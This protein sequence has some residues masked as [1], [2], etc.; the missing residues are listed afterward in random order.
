MNIV[1]THVHVWD[2]GHEHLPW[3]DGEGPVLKRNWSPRDYMRE[4]RHDHGYKVEQAIYIEVDRAHEERPAENHKAIKL[5]D[6]AETPFAGACIA[7]TLTSPDFSRYIEEWDQWTQIKG[8]RQ[9]LHVPSSPPHAC[10]TETFMKNV[11]LLGQKELVY[12]ACL[13]CEELADL[14]MVA[15]ECPGTTIVLDHMGIVDADIVGVEHPVAEELTYREAWRHNMRELGALP[16][17]VCKIS[18]LN[19]QREWSTDSLARAVDVALESFPADRV[20]FASNFPVLHVSMSL[21]TWITSMLTITEG[22]DSKDKN[23]LF[24]GNARRV[25]KLK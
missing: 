8:V 1:D 18:G 4:L 2:L 7:G 17:V 5:V 13:R 9:V 21:D 3:L 10:L 24:S 23:A 15:K 16:N 14:V 20:M 22:L 12:E 25:Y 6:A 19:P 11:R